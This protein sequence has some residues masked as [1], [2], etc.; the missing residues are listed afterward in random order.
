M[1]KRNFQGDK[2][3]PKYHFMP[4]DYV[5]ILGWPSDEEF[6][7]FVIR[8]AESKGGQVGHCDIVVTSLNMPIAS[9]AINEDVVSV[10]I[11]RLKLVEKPDPQ[12]T[13]AEILDA[14]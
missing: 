13:Y 9:T 7:G 11:D 8:N 4:G 5:Q 14:F 1:A 3:Q 10:P 6:H 2:P 12:Y